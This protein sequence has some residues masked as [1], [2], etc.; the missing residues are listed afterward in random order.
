MG[1]GM[2][3]I[4]TEALSRYK[5]VAVIT[6]WFSALTLLGVFYAL[7]SPALNGN[8]EIQHFECSDVTATS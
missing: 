4:T 6:L 8:S 5:A 7:L 3:V 1:S 2:L